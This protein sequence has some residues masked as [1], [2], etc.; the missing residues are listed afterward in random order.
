L[1]QK[2]SSTAEKEENQIEPKIIKDE[3][4]STSMTYN[5]KKK[6]KMIYS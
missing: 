6:I 5:N 1:G 4:T 3:R 2:T